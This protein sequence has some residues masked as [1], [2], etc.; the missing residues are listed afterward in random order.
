[1]WREKL[2][3]LTNWIIIYSKCGKTR[4]IQIRVYTVAGNWEKVF[5]F[6]ISRDHYTKYEPQFG[7]YSL[8]FVGSPSSEEKISIPLKLLPFIPYLLIQSIEQ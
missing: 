3:N 1:M 5:V 8:R 2:A 7:I 6:F 4:E